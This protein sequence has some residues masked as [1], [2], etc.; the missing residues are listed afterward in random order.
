MP[1]AD[2]EKR[3]AY[4]REYAQR[5]ELKEKRSSYIKAWAARNIDKKVEAERR[6][7]MDR[8]AQVLIS[9]ARIRAKRKGLDFDL[10]QHVDTIQKRI[11]RGHCEV[12]GFPFNLEG[13]RTFDSPSLDR[14]NPKK[15]YVFTNV[16]VVIHLA[17]VAM[18]DWGDK[19]L[20]AVMEN[21]LIE[22]ELLV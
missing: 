8:R 22:T 11:D 20:K 6:R 13:G 15:G 17:N 9:N 16:R 2:A 21:W 18:G 19:V 3:R 10:D 14:I 4:S 1:Y 12:T 5:P 7:R